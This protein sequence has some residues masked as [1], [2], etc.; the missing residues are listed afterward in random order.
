MVQLKKLK[1]IVAAS[2]A[3]GGGGRTTQVGA[4]LMVRVRILYL[5]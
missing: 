5:A 4:C 3:M 2:P 1:A